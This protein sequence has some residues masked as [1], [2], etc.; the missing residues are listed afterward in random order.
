MKQLLTKGQIALLVIISV[1]VIDQIIKVL[2]KTTMYMHESI[3]ITDWFY[4][5]F[6]E[7]N[8]MAFGMEVFGKLFLSCFRII[9]VGVID[10]YLFKIIKKGLKTGFI[11]CVSLILAGALGNI[12]DSI[13]YGVLFSGSTHSAIATFMPEDGGYASWFY[14]RV[15]DMFYFPIIDTTWPTWIPFVGGDRFVFF[16]PI[17]NFA[18]SA[19]TCGIV[20]LLLFYS[21][22]MN[23]TYRQEHEKVEK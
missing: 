3:R 9:A 12:I 13:F 17:F 16:S 15:V 21:K 4:I 7:N 11:I 22:Y 19:I 6:T 5:Y 8:G 20:A 1:L 10:W 2:I 14:G 18:D 23:T